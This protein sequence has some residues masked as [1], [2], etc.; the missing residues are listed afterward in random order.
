MLDPQDADFFY[1]KGKLDY[2]KQIGVALV[3]LKRYEEALLMYN[4][5]ILLDPEDAEYFYNKGSQNNYI[6][7]R[8]YFKQLR[9]I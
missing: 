3:K 6:K 7:I 2:F 1:N 9:E 4:H 5:A 8:T